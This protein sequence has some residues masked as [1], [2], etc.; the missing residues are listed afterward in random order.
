MHSAHLHP[1]V[2]ETDCLH[3]ILGASKKSERL[4]PTVCTVRNTFCWLWRWLGDN[5]LPIISKVRLYE[6]TIQ[7]QWRNV[8]LL[9]LYLPWFDYFQLEAMPLPCSHLYEIVGDFDHFHNQNQNTIGIDWY[10]S[11]HYVF[12]NVTVKVTEN[13][14]ITKSWVKVYIP[15]WLIMKYTPKIHI[16]LVFSMTLMF[17][18]EIILWKY[19]STK[20]QHFAR[21]SKICWM[22][23][24][25]VL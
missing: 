1:D 9:Y 3:Q 5:E 2:S 7:W 14:K 23:Q 16:T 18:Q 13:V 24:S 10:I 19:V 22:K 15:Y 6:I 21:R 25:I 17:R 11:R 20:D 4:E 8:T 12:Y